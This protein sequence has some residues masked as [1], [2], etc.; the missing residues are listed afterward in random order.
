MVQTFFFFRYLY[1]EIIFWLDVA[2]FCFFIGSTM[3]R[4]DLN[5]VQLSDSIDLLPRL[6]TFCYI[7]VWYLSVAKRVVSQNDWEL[8]PFYRQYHLLFI[9]FLWQE[10]HLLPANI[11]DIFLFFFYI[12]FRISFYFLCVIVSHFP[13]SRIPF[14]ISIFLAAF[15]LCIVISIAFRFPVLLNSVSHC[16]AIHEIE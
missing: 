13:I 8:S 3:T 6:H 10:T 15:C 16:L 2:F 11:L 12:L 4:V 9:A 14:S 7:Y 5:R 1:G